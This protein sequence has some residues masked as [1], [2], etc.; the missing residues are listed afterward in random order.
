MKLYI[1]NMVCPRCITSV[2][3]ILK[4]NHLQAKYVRLG[5]VELVK[6]PAAR[7]IEIFT[8]ELL[9]TGF[10]LLDDQKTQLIEEVKNLLIQKVQNG[11]VEEHFSLTKFI[12][13]KVFKDYSAVSKLFSQLES[14]TL[15]QFFNLQKIEKVKEW[16]MY[17]EQS[18]TQIAFNLG[19]SS[20]QHLSSQFKNLTGMTPSQFKKLGA[21]HR[22][23]IDAV[24]D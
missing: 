2:E 17:N 16:L 23:P 11:N 24:K 10:E 13:E 8:K 19:Y 9:E 21:L 4:R 12:G 18:L 5:E 7:Q 1:K 20:T 14:I 3:Q 15:E 22:K 6:K